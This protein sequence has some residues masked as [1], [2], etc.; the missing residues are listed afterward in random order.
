MGVST[1]KTALNSSKS[2][3][4]NKSDNRILSYLKSTEITPMTK[5]QYTNSRLNK[6]EPAC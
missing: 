3:S 2:K 4:E 1:K 5:E 6:Y